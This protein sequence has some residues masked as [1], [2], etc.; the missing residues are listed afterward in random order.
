MTEDRLFDPGSS[1]AG[2]VWGLD[3]STKR[4]ALA[5]QAEAGDGV[6]VGL[7][8]IE[9]GEPHY[10]LKRALQELVPWM[11]AQ[12][13]PAIVGIEQPFAGSMSKVHPQSFYMVGIVLAA[14]GL[15]APA[16]AHV[17][18]LPPQTWKSKSVGHGHAK[19]PAIL[20]WARRVQAFTG[21]CPG[22]ENGLRPEPEG[23]WRGNCRAQSSAHDEADAIGVCVAVREL[24]AA[25]R[26]SV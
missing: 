8:S 18:M 3:V 9:Q 10:R 16:D 17:E 15:V 21:T 19:K 23:K 7:L 14:V 24:V 25:R 5:V 13:K 6:S 2:A 4:V 22:C 11:Q 12:A 26:L 20:S 1:V